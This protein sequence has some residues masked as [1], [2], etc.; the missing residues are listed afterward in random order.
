MNIKD[1]ILFTL[2]ILI[3][4]LFYKTI[5][6]EK[7]NSNIDLTKEV[8][9]IYKIDTDALRNMASVSKYLYENKQ[10]CII[11]INTAKVNN[12][13]INGNLNVNGDVTFSYYNNKKLDIFPRYMIIAWGLEDYLPLGWVICDGRK[14]FINGIEIETPDLRSFMIIGA[15][16][17]NANELTSR[18]YKTKGGTKTVLLEKKNLP[19]HNH[20]KTIAYGTEESDD[21]SVYIFNKKFTLGF[22]SYEI[23]DGTDGIWRKYNTELKHETFIYLLGGG[24]TNEDIIRSKNTS[25]N[26]LPPRLG[27]N[28]INFTQAEWETQQA[29]NNL[30]PCISFFY[31]MKL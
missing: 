22:L 10:K 31:I 18:P 25:L 23:P 30:P 16:N 26:V 21:T 24:K 9:D 11:P 15:S 29:H 12:L 8:N 7:F 13:N 17:K 6:L 28:F 14:H 5:K 2:I 3:I 20:K 4:Y 27:T 19:K 1:I